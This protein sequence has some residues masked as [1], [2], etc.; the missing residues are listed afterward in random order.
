[1]TEAQGIEIVLDL[2][3]EDF[4]TCSRCRQAVPSS[5]IAGRDRKRDFIC[6]DCHHADLAEAY[7]SEERGAA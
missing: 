3:R 1:M 7:F 2:W 5:W 6:E 4:T